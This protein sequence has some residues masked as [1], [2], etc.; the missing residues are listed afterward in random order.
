MLMKIA[1]KF[2]SLFCFEF[3]KKHGNIIWKLTKNAVKLFQEAHKLSQ[4]GIYG[5]KTYAK[6][7]TY[8]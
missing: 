4:D 8:K 2:E 5:P 1:M 7:K 3:Q 6:A